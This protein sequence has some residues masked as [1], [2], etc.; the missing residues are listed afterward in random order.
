[1]LGR[2]WVR[3][4]RRDALQHFEP[5]DVKLKA[6]GRAL[7]S[8]HLAR[9]AQR[10]FLRQVARLLEDFRGY[11]ALHDHTL[12][13]PGAVANERKQELAALAQVVKPAL[14]QNLL[15]GV[16][17]NVADF[18][19]GRQRT[20]KRRSQESEDH[21]AISRQRLRVLGDR[22]TLN[23]ERTEYLRDLS[24][25]AL[26]ARRPQRTSHRLRPTVALGIGIPRVP[27]HVPYAKRSGHENS[28]PASS[29]RPF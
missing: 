25:E 23:T 21:R 27:A 2:N 12:D 20:S 16:L 5:R 24:V 15:A 6:A 8:P 26:E 28:S 17:G 1:L 7:V 10:R 29:R 4:F 13:D 3:V 22:Q 11:C 18:D 19:D 9:D 14:D